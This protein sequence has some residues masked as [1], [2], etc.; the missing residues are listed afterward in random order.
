MIDTAGVQ[1]LTDWM[2]GLAELQLTPSSGGVGGSPLL[3]ELQDGL[4]AGHGDFAFDARAV[5]DGEDLG[6]DLAL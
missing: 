2:N 1:L 6:D 3:F 5:G 4:A